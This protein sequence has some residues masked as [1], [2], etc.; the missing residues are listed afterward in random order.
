MKCAHSGNFLHCVSALPHPRFS[1][2]GP[3]WPARPLN[4]G[5]SDAHSKRD[6]FSEAIL[7]V[8]YVRI[9]SDKMNRT[10]QMNVPDSRFVFE[11]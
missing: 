11:I 7:Q 8:P 2:R 10:P 5:E 1:A 9:D 3:G 6:T 4:E